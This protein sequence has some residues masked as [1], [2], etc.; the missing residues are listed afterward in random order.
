MAPLKIRLIG[1]KWAPNKGTAA[2]IADSETSIAD[3]I[4]T[5]LLPALEIDRGTFDQYALFTVVDKKPGVEVNK[6]DT[7]SAAGLDK[8][9]WL[10]LR[11]VA[12]TATV[13]K[14]AAAAPPAPPPPK[15]KSAAPVASAAPPPPPPKPKSAAPAA[16]AAAPPPP[17]PKAPAGS[18]STA[19][20]ASSPPPPPPPRPKAPPAAGAVPPPQPPPPKAKAPTAAAAPPPPPPRPKA[21]AAP[22]AASAGEHPSHHGEVEAVTGGGALSTTAPEG[23][24]PPPAPKAPPPQP[25]KAPS[26]AP[27]GAPT[28]A[29]KSPP[30]PV[31]TPPSSELS[32]GDDAV[33]RKSTPPTPPTTVGKPSPQ[34]A[35]K[36]PAPQPAARPAPTAAKTAPPAAAQAVAASDIVVAERPH[37]TNDDHHGES[38]EDDDHHVH[39][40]PSSRHRDGLENDRHHTSPDHQHYSGRSAAVDASALAAMQQR[41]ALDEERQRVLLLEKDLRVSMEREIQNLKHDVTSRLS[42]EKYK[43][44]DERGRME[45]QRSKL[46]TGLLEGQSKMMEELDTLIKAQAKQQAAQLTGG[47]GSGSHHLHAAA[48]EELRL[49]NAELRE[50]L[51]LRQQQVANTR[52]ATETELQ[53]VVKMQSQLVASVAAMQTHM[54]SEM[55]AMIGSSAGGAGGAVGRLVDTS[56]DGTNII[57]GDALISFLHGLGLSKYGPTLLEHEVDLPT[58]FSMTEAEMQ[59]VGIHAI[60]ARKKIL[61]EVGR[62]KRPAAAAAPFD[63]G[64]MSSTSFQ[65]GFAPS[66]S[67]MNRSHLAIAPPAVVVGPYGSG[68]YASEDP[69][70]SAYPSPS[71]ATAAAAAGMDP[72]QLKQHSRILQGFFRRYSPELMGRAGHIVHFFA[73]QL[74]DVY[75]ALCHRHEIRVS[76][77]RSTMLHFFRQYDFAYLTPAVDIILHVHQGREAEFAE[78]LVLE[79]IGLNS[80][81]LTWFAIV[82]P[83][84]PQEGHPRNEGEADGTN[85]ATSPP[86]E[87]FYFC[88]LVDLAQWEVPAI[89]AERGTLRVYPVT[90]SAAPAATALRGAAPLTSSL[91]PRNPTPTEVEAIAS[92]DRWY[93]AYAVCM[94]MIH[95]PSRL[96][97]FEQLVAQY[98]V[99]TATGGPVPSGADA[100]AASPGPPRVRGLDLCRDLAARYGCPM[101][102]GGK[103]LLRVPPSHAHQA[104]GVSS[105]R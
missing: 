10:W 1:D 11:K 25:K 48:I 57:K 12:A 73:A 54:T 3:A 33:G 94:L 13:A 85:G 43:L 31:R 70:L 63:D 40:P 62:M 37:A 5:V 60:G 76:M 28:A 64:S 67:S 23:A 103:P 36:A 4:D 51:A 9:P 7:W 21:P 22:A 55:N 49:Q 74:A 14:S 90:F 102:G 58:L 8:N 61:L 19:A 6:A 59:G 97:Q 80:Q 27:T 88:A 50:A 47:G 98:V 99:A 15:A 52:V 91:L 72:Q 46:V 87:C 78:R 82:V 84:S 93:I 83:P 100:T 92:W 68:V 69:I 66:S 29:S 79:R 105:T 20:A 77:Y 95:D 17:Q 2:E 65:G 96:P 56:G 41:A 24:P 16:T 42:D 81:A 104:S 32:G 86:H 89:V 75:A 26:A 38:H 53:Q 101:G 71:G 45:E 39:S 35:A 44:L 30:P 34:S 18:P